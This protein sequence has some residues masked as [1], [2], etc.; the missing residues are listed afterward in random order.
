MLFGKRTNRS[1]SARKMR[2][3]VANQRLN[4]V[5]AL[6]ETGDIDTKLN[7][8]GILATINMINVKRE[9]LKSLNDSTESVALKAAD[10]LDYMGVTPAERE[11]VTKCRN[12]W[13]KKSN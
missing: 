12:Y 3:W 11:E 7:A 10:S 4:K 6:L 13:K 8:I 1:V 5:V 2:E 9:L